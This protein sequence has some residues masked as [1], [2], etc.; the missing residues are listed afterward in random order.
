MKKVVLHHI[1]S[2]IGKKS[3][4]GY[5]SEKI[6]EYSKDK[7]KINI[8]CRSNKS[9]KRDDNIWTI[10]ISFYLSRIFIVISLYLF[11]NF[12][13]RKYELFFFNIFS[14]PY[15]I[16]HYLKNI[17]H[18]RYFHS[19]DTS[20][21]LLIIVKKLNYYIIKDCAMTPAKSSV[22]ES[23]KN[24]EFYY[25]TKNHSKT[26]FLEKKIFEISQIII[27]P[28]LYTSNFIIKHYEIDKTKLI[29]IPFGV[30]IRNEIRN[31]KRN[32]YLKSN[33]I[34]TISLGFV[35]LVNMRKGIRW[36]IKVLNE[37]K[38]ESNFSFELHIYGKIFKDEIKT[39]KS[40]NFIIFKHGFET[41]KSIIFN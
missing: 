28:S 25:D 22:L 39:I 7:I 41:N 11:S 10:D 6:Y 37:L 29:T 16:F 32:N 35:G 15:I 30:E 38:E 40:A 31:K 13:S 9:L 23:K 14:L 18:K 21:W 20:L 24:R 36:F 17:N 5:R 4:V 3:S 27:S 12:P 33:N 26:I 8:I 2:D 19:W 34:K 1:S